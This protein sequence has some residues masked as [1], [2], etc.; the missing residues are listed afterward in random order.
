MTWIISLGF[1]PFE[2]MDWQSNQR[3]TSVICYGICRCRYLQ[4]LRKMIIVG[5]IIIIIIIVNCD[6]LVLYLVVLN[7]CWS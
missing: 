5:V 7:M 4:L 1:L 6:V 3:E 2:A